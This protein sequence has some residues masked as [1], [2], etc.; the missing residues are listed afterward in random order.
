MESS[1]ISKLYQPRRPV[2]S[3]RVQ[4]VPMAPI[5]LQKVF[6]RFD[7]GRYTTQDAGEF[8]YHPGMTIGQFVD[9]N[10]IDVSDQ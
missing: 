5:D 10:G 3:H 7:L 4:L 6:L 9:A 2:S 8:R 1:L